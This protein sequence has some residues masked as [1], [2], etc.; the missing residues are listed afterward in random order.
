M[1]GLPFIKR[2][3]YCQTNHESDEFVSVKVICVVGGVAW[4]DLSNPSSKRL[5]AFAVFCCV[6]SLIRISSRKEIVASTTLACLTNWFYRTFYTHSLYF[7]G[8]S[9]ESLQIIYPNE[10]A[11][12]SAMHASSIYGIAEKRPPD[13]KSCCSKSTSFV[14]D[15]LFLSCSD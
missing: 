3:G 1:L 5:T 10:Y 15:S 11:S 13:W 4:F 8:I 14:F 6:D 2:I 12:H 7:V 9:L